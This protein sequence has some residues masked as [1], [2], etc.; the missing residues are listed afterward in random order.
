MARR[1]TPPEPIRPDL[2]PDQKRRCILRIEQCIHELEAFDPQKV[3]KRYRVPEVMALEAAIDTALSAAFGH[4]TVDYRRYRGAATLDHGP[5]SVVSD[6]D[7]GA[8]GQY[9]DAVEAQKYLAEGKEQS[10]TLLKQAVRALHDEITDYIGLYQ[11]PAGPPLPALPK[12][13]VFVVHGHDEAALQGVARF[14]EQLE[15]KAV[16]LREQPDAGRASWWP[17]T[18]RAGTPERYFRAGIFCRKAGQGANLLASQR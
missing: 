10:I 3:Q 1:P 18:R 14:L 11:P 2:T 16:I 13:K 4:G 17:A 8:G 6:Y 7:F 9:S 15:L 5:A 12:N